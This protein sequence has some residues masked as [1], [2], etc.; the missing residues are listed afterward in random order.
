MTAGL[1]RLGEDLIAV[2]ICA[3]C[4]WTQIPAVKVYGEGRGDRSN[5][6]GP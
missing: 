1:G 4:E 6:E 3:V 5:G 2:L